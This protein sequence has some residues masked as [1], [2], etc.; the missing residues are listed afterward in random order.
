MNEKRKL[1]MT[2]H[3]LPNGELSSELRQLL[4]EESAEVEISDAVV[5]KGFPFQ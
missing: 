3:D 4:M 2:E 1:I 5:F